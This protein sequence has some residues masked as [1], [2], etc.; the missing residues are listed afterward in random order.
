[1]EALIW[2]LLPGFAAVA[3]G[4]LAWF[5]MQ[6]RMDVALAQQRER[7]AESRGALDAERNAV[8]D[9]V[10]I[11]VHAAEERAQRQALDNFLAELK[12]EQRHYTRENRLLLHNRR[13]VV[14][15]ERMCFR[16]LPLSDWIEHE[17]PLDDGA[18]VERLVQDM[19]VFDKA[20]VNI[21][22]I[23]RPHRKALA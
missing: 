7:L 19:T 15:Q 18:D 13:S 5:V 16:N 11:A 17:I 12:V 23:P 6:S 1:M 3:T 8:R 21:A 9:S 14:L 22:D 10:A 4:L 20:V 2:I